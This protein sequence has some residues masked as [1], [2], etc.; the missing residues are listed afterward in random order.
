MSH[1]NEPEEIVAI[2]FVNRERHIINFVKNE[3]KFGFFSY[4]PQLKNPQIGDLLKV[5]FEKSKDNK[6]YK[7]IHVQ[8][9]DANESCEAVKSFKG[10]I[11]IANKNG[12]GFVDDIF[13]FP[14]LVSKFSLRDGQEIEGKAVLSFDK[15]KDNWGWK[16][17]EV[18]VSK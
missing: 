3:N 11:R 17:F 13:I 15:K 9:A 4:G 5:K 8:P 2:E 14:K 10:P 1:A 7:T 16:V 12:F 18:A 6:F